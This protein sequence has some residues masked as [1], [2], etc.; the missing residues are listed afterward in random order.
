MAGAVADDLISE[1]RTWLADG[2]NGDVA[3]ALAFAVVSGRVPV[4][5]K[6][7]ALMFDELAAAGED[8]QVLND[9]ERIEDDVIR[10]L[11]WV[12]GPVRPHELH[13]LHDDHPRPPLLLDLTDPAAPAGLDQIDAA[14]VAAA[15]DEPG[16]NAVWRA[17]R[18]PVE[19]SP[20]PP[21]RRVFI[22]SAPPDLPTHELPLLTARLQEV[23]VAA[24]ESEPQVEVCR[25]DLE[26][27]DYQS[28]AAA[29]A[30]LLWAREP[31]VE[32]RLARVFDAVDPH[33]GPMFDPDHPL[34][35]DFDE[36]ER[37]LDYLEA[38]LPIMT[39]TSLMAD[40]LDP[41]HP[42]VVPL[43]FRT[44]GEWIWT[45]TVS[46]YLERHSL[47][48]DPDL[49]SHLR[50]AGPTPPSVSG[51]A[52]HRILSFLQRPDDSEPVWVV[53]PVAGPGVR[54]AGV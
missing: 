54:S 52:V 27:P 17:W 11:P 21:S 44:D 24:G 22:V 29:Q 7:A 6:D 20:W 39:T 12:F 14:T 16:V 15:G 32:I 51:V 3:Q 8:T 25:D 26:V 45:D 34:I 38:A 41:E 31:A 50:S 30:A 37:L 40:I 19:G 36:A 53:P 4:L 2:Q 10:P 33:T 5:A 49:L 18:S 1:A 28:T 47:A 13:E 48:P 9:L 42:E 23:L 35:Q 43:S 46:Y